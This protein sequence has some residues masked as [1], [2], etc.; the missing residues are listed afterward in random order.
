MEIL[1]RIEWQKEKW[2]MES[3]KLETNGY[4]KLTVLQ[5]HLYSDSKEDLY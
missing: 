2:L 1:F 4:Y 3:W 5:L